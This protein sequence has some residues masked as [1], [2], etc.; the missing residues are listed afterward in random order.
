[1]SS[2]TDTSRFAEGFYT[3]PKGEIVELLYDNGPEYGFLVRDFFGNDVKISRGILGKAIPISF[4]PSPSEIWVRSAEGVVHH[5]GESKERAERKAPDIMDRLSLYFQKMFRFEHFTVDYR[6]YYRGGQHEEHLPRSLASEMTQH[7]S[8]VL[9]AKGVWTE[10]S[11]AKALE[12]IENPTKAGWEAFFPTAR[13]ERLSVSSSSRECPVTGYSF[14]WDF[15]GV[16]FRLARRYICE[17]EQTAAEKKASCSRGGGAKIFFSTVWRDVEDFPQADGHLPKMELEL[18]CPSGNLLFA[19]VLYD[20]FGEGGLFQF[21]VNTEAG[22]RQQAEHL[23]KLGAWHVYNGGRGNVYLKDGE[24]MI[25]D[26]PEEG[27]LRPGGNPNKSRDYLPNPANPTTNGW[28]DKG[29]IAGDL[30]W[31]YA[32]DE[33]TLPKDWQKKLS[34]PDE[35]MVRVKVKPGRYRLVNHY[36]HLTRDS[37]GPSCIIS[38][39]GK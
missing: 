6:G 11:K 38:R 25:G 17:E 32:C 4:R 18:D 10:A 7:M 13:R 24:I 23:L 37:V 21:E 36:E 12:W 15:D 5:M 30:R 19:N 20:V 34:H 9:E 3:L 8:W 35:R 33:S 14:E 29:S 28:K 1:M 16:N 22:R 39:I 26:F 31:F 27:V 2:I